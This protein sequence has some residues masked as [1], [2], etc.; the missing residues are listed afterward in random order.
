MDVKVSATVTNFCFKYDLFRQRKIIIK[1][2]F[3]SDMTWNTN[4]TEL[5]KITVFF[6]NID[7]LD[8]EHLQLVPVLS[9][10]RILLFLLQPEQHFFHLGA[11]SE[12]K[13]PGSETSKEIFFPPEYGK[14]EARFHPCNAFLLL[15]LISFGL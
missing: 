10:A 1:K 12:S 7:F 15:P 11:R 13:W 2:H 8:R 3:Y 6:R 9:A 14:V 4:S 5:E